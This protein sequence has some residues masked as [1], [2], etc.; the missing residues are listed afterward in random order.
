MSKHIGPGKVSGP[1]RDLAPTGQRVPCPEEVDRIIQK[2]GL[3]TRR[4]R[5]MACIAFRRNRWMIDFYDQH[6][7]RR[8]VSLKEGTTKTEAKRMLREIENK[9]D[10][11]TFIAEKKMPV[12]DEVAR[13]WLE[14]KRPNIR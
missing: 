4:G 3:F 2:R 8:V 14:Y 13:D 7:K 12:F 9:I 10:K 5:K 11:G 6:G 1:I